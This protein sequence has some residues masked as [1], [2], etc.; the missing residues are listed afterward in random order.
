MAAVYDS[1]AKQYKNTFELPFRKHIEEYTYFQ[2]LGDLSGKSI[3]DLACG[4]GR[5]TRKFKQ[6]GAA[7]V[8][9]VDISGKMIELARQKETKKLLGIEYIIRDVLD[10]G[11]IGNF[12]LVV[13]SFLLNYS[14]TKKE[15]LEMCQN[16]YSNLKP[17]GRFITINNNPELSPSSYS[18]LKKY[19]YTKKIPDPFTEGAPITIIFTTAEGQVSFDNE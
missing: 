2:V 9:G 6:K 15:L 7:H 1:I 3:L 5:Y 13:A 10:L 11:K 17:G 18:K 14:R 4:E 8:V 12:D 16:I 19:G